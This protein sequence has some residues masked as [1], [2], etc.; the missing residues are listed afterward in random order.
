MDRILPFLP[1][2]LPDDIS[3]R[4]RRGNRPGRA[5]G[6]LGPRRCRTVPGAEPHGLRIH[7]PLQSQDRGGPRGRRQVLGGPTPSS[8]PVI[9]GPARPLRHDGPGSP[10][11]P[12]R[13]GPNCTGTNCPTGILRGTP[14]SS[15]GESAITSKNSSGFPLPT[16]S[17]LPTEL[18]VS[19]RHMFWVSR[20]RIRVRGGTGTRHL[21]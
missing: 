12:T 17:P 14:R 1:L 7:R 13:H 4:G 9:P 8:F 6:K 10:K 2:P 5:G 18:A 3:R 21:E 16:H 11:S 15:A 20:N 19:C